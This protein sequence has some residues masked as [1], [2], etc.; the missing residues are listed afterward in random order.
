[1]SDAGSM[2]FGPKARYRRFNLTL[3]LRTKPAPEQ[4][5]NE[6]DVNHFVERRELDA[7]PQDFDTIIALR[8]QDGAELLEQLLPQLIKAVALACEPVVE[9]RRPVDPEPLE[10]VA[11][12][13]CS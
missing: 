3:G 12:K 10:K 11:A 13:Q 8:R 6:L 5:A 2:P 4:R 7:L 9:Q 1:M